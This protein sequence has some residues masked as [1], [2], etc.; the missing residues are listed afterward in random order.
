MSFRTIDVAVAASI[1]SY[2]TTL[3]RAAG[4][5]DQL[6]RNL[7]QVDRKS[8]ST[9]RS[10][11]GLRDT[12]R[13]A[14]A[15]FAGFV[16]AQ[17]AGRALQFFSGEVRKAISEATG[18][19]QAVGGT[20]AVF[21]DASGT[22][23]RFA[24]RSA[25]VV[26][27]SKRQFREATTFVGSQLKA[28]GFGGEQ[29]A[30]QAIQLTKIAADQVAL[31]GGTT[32]EANAAILAA[33]SRSE[34]DPLERFGITINAAARDANAAA[35][36]FKK[37]DGEYS[38][39]AKT[40]G[41][42]KAIQDQATIAQGQ[43]GREAET[44]AGKM[45]RANARLDD[46]RATLG[47]ALLPAVVSFASAISEK[48]SPAIE[49]LASENGPMLERLGSQFGDV[50]IQLLQALIENLPEGLRL[51]QAV[52]P[53][54][55][56]LAGGAASLAP[57]V[58]Q[59]ADVVTGLPA[60]VLAAAA[61]FVVLNGPVA[62]LFGLG[63]S[64]VGVLGKLIEKLLGVESAGAAAGRGLAAA[65]GPAAA[66]GA[67]AVIGGTAAGLDVKAANSRAGDFIASLRGQFDLATAEGAAKYRAA[68]LAEQ[69]R[70]IK[71]GDTKRTLGNLIGSAFTDTAD[72]AVAKSK[73]IDAELEAM[74]SAAEQRKRASTANTSKLAKELGITTEQVREL[75]R[76]NKVDLADGY[77]S[78]RAP[79]GDA[80]KAAGIFKGEAADAA[81]SIE[82]LAAGMQEAAPPLEKLAE[83]L[84]LK[85]GAEALEKLT[86]KWA[87]FGEAVNER[88]VSFGSIL[89]KFDPDLE[90]KGIDRVSK[91]E[92][93][94][95][96][97]MERVSD[98][99]RDLDDVRYDLRTGRVI[100]RDD[101]LREQEALRN[102]GKAQ[103]AAAQAE[104]DLAKARSEVLSPAEQIAKLERDRLAQIQR[105]VRL[106][107][108]ASRAGLDPAFLREA[109]AAGPGS[110]DALEAILSSP[111]LVS[112][113]NQT[114]TQIRGLGEVLEGYGVIVDATADGF[115]GS[116]EEM[117]AAMEASKDRIGAGAD[118]ARD[119]L[120]AALG[121]AQGR[122][123]AIALDIGHGIPD[124]IKAGIE[125]GADD[126]KAAAVKAVNDTMDAAAA[127][128]AAR[129][130]TDDATAGLPVDG[131]DKGGGPSLMDQ[132]G[133]VVR[134]FFR[135]RIGFADGGTRLPGVASRQTAIYAEPEA[136]PESFIPWAV[137]KR[138]TATP[139]LRT[140][141]R[142]FGYELVKP[143]HRFHDG[144][145]LR[146][147][148][149]LG[150]TYAG[151][152]RSG[153]ESVTEDRST[154]ITGPVTVM[155]ANLSDFERQVQ[156]KAALTRAVGG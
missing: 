46:S 44:A 1:G 77:E 61:A 5:T 127:A 136:A 26:G 118:A 131:P 121:D 73:A 120:I 101:I 130:A 79:I 25:D 97:A 91:A 117:A 156:R 8:K 113:V 125:A 128:A 64:T 49:R 58:E 105:F 60:P 45:Q 139:V 141:A 147:M 84:K 56:A 24:E 54:L 55:T 23:D 111:E 140:T 83:A 51:L 52:I 70:I 35:L 37:V 63:K 21:K 14:G 42:L 98:V 106:V 80:A 41:V 104:R 123:L 90:A 86:E 13:T 122:A 2:T 132:I 145:Y 68:L 29:A 76:A 19:E 38:R 108:E 148:A 31:L 93:G 143:S 17:V 7:D 67:G 115:I 75:A 53:I 47:N 150:T 129:T 152:V 4:A 71:S 57:V 6:G 124:A 48:V 74:F 95:A 43:F 146:P 27:L 135:P 18:L 109:L 149:G 22:I 28:V 30:Q 62:G 81:V 96:D 99:Q 88:A 155:A 153:P 20:E 107:E 144:G 11:E 110:S 85:G 134:G 78:L 142:A 114:E 12:L 87:K 34:F 59:V 36:G 50:F 100:R 94:L 89:D 82:E 151:S 112:L 10:V 40:L 39:Q 16:A 138:L 154:K 65:A 119:A 32:Q 137:S 133:N 72:N 33:V 69:D 116:T 126:T 3:Q 102:L 66:F 103:A 15:A 92:E 9:E